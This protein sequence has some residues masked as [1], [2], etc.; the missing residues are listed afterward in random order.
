M[1]RLAGSEETKDDPQ[2][3]QV[4]LNLLKDLHLSCHA[5]THV[6]EFLEAGC[7]WLKRNSLHFNVSREP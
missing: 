4:R 1:F 2:L 7:K 3:N 5:I 6:L